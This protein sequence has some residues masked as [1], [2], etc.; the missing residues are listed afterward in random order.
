MTEGTHRKSLWIPYAFVGFFGLVL[1]A[2]GALIFFATTTFSGLDQ[3]NAYQR[4]LAYNDALAAA[5]EQAALGWTTDLV[6]TP[7]T[8]SVG[9]LQLS[10]TDSLAQPVRGA[11]VHAVLERPTNADLDFQV[12]L[13]PDGAGGYVAELAWP[14]IGLWDVSI[15]VEANGRRYQV[16]ERLLVR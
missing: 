16:D 11:L 10:V 4:G 8:A 5:R 1:A 9:R 13:E 15:T 7:I 6:H 14:A 2:N 3:A 12:P